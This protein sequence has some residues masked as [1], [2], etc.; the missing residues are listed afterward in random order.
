MKSFKRLDE[1]KLP[2]KKEFHKSLKKEHARDE[3]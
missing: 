1:T 3:V 2:N